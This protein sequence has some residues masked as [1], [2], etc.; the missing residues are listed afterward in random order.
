[1]ATRNPRDPYDNMRSETDS[2][3]KNAF[4]IIPGDGDLAVSVRGL[5]IG[6]SGKV[7]VRMHGGANN[8]TVPGA[9]ITFDNVVA[10]TILPIRI[11]K[12]WADAN[13]TATGLVGLY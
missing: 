9:N 13:T 4:H 3:A 11:D 2:P 7:F 8:V 5:Y 10:G 6:N 12:V 1:M